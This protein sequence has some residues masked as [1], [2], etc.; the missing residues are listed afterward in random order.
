MQVAWVRSLVGKGPTGHTACPPAK[1][2]QVTNCPSPGLPASL[3]R[4]L[5]PRRYSLESAS[6]SHCARGPPP[7]APDP[8]HPHRVPSPVTSPLPETPQLCPLAF[9]ACDER[10]L[11]LGWTGNLF[12][13][14]LVSVP[15]PIHSRQQPGPPRGPR[16]EAARRIPLQS[17]VRRLC[18]PGRCASLSRH[19]AAPPS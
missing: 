19:P 8:R 18:K 12:P 5:S 9:T 15:S 17:R 2:L 14:N 16:P 7:A 6:G 11:S 4:P 13:S 10:E 1:V 3:P